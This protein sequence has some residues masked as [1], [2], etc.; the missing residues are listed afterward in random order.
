MI[1]VGG[2]TFVVP[3]SKSFSGGDSEQ[4]VPRGSSL[5]LCMGLLPSYLQFI[6]FELMVMLLLPNI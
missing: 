6:V 4:T 3:G 1:V 5:A 2:S